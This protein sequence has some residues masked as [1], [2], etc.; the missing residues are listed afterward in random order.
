MLPLFKLFGQPEKLD[1]SEWLQPDGGVTA[2]AVCRCDFF[3]AG[4]PK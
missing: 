2:T 4:T 1:K 3:A